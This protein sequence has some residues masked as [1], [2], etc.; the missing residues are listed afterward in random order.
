MKRLGIA[1]MLFTIVLAHGC[2]ESNRSRLQRGVDLATSSL[3]DVGRNPLAAASFASLMDQGGTVMSYI[4]ANMPDDTN[5]PNFTSE[6]PTQTWTVLVKPGPG[7]N[8][9]IIEG[10]GTDLTKPVITD[11]G[12]VVLYH[13]H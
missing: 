11:H 9:Y 12:T 2:A 5:L 1:A 3:E 7:Q 13:R 8:D 10:Y 6:M 4:A